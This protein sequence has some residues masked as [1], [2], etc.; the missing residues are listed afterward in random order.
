MFG[1]PHIDC[2]C[3]LC[4]IES[5]QHSPGFAAVVTASFDYHS[6]IINMRRWKDG[7]FHTE[8]PLKGVFN[9]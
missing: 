4:E 7:R 3:E 8:G 1:F 6:F 2:D 5:F 9:D